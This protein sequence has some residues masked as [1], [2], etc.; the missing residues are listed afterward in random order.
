MLYHFTTRYSEVIGRENAYPVNIP[1]GYAG[2]AIF[3][4]I[5]GFLVNPLKAKTTNPLRFFADKYLRLYPGF[6]L[7]SVVVAPCA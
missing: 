1:W 6:L 7:A 3:F 5:T 4:I 2:W